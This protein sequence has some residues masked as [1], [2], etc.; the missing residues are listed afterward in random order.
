MK[1]LM[2]LDGGLEMPRARG[3]DGEIDFQMLSQLGRGTLRQTVAQRR[4]E[5]Q[6]AMQKSSAPKQTPAKSE[7]ASTAPSAQP[8]KRKKQQKVARVS[9]HSSRAVKHPRTINPI[10][11][12]LAGCLLA[13]AVLVLLIMLAIAR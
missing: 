9:K 12:A 7:E 6:A 4:K 5:L 13:T 2:D 1:D 3:R 10:P 11:R 8:G